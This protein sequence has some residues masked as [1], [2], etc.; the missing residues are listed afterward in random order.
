[1]PSRRWVEL[2]AAAVLV[3]AALEEFG[4]L[5]HRLARQARAWWEDIEH[6]DHYGT[7]R[8]TLDVLVPRIL[9]RRM[10]A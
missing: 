3:A 10:R 1:M 2:A 8:S 6:R 7:E 4:Y 9:L 5:R